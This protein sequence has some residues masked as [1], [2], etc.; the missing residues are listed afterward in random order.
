M[1]GDFFTYTMTGSKGVLLLLSVAILLRCL[2]SMLREK[3]D[4]ETWA[5]LRYG[6][7]R[8]PV[9]HWEVIIGRAPDADVCIP[10][11]EVARCVRPRRRLGRQH[12]CG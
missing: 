5:Y 7:E 8:F 9:Q 10:L 1:Q 2:R 11:R 6:R 12:L 3:Y 4:P